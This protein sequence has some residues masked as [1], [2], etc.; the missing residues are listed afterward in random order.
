MAENHVMQL[1]AS[2]VTVIKSNAASSDDPPLM[3]LNQN[4]YSDLAAYP[5]GD[6]YLKYMHALHT[7]VASV[8]GEVLWRSHVHG[9]AIGCEHDAV[10]EILA[11]WYP[12]HAAFL[13]LAQADGAKEMLDRRQRCVEHAVIHRCPTDASAFS[14]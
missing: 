5:E 13:A 4:R 2:E 14:P 10:D 6:E 7:T 9:Q 12:S 11:V 3:M 1:Q 8:G